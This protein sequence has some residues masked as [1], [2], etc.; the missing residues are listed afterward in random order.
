MKGYLKLKKAANYLDMCENTF[1]EYVLP[2]VK[3]KR[4]G[5]GIY[6]AVKDLEEFMNDGFTNE[7]IELDA[8]KILKKMGA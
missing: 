6:F 5:R 2:H 1:R 3:C 8:K 7:K 4:I